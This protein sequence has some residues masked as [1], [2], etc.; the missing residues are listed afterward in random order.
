MAGFLV[1]ARL[2]V[3]S[4]SVT[5]YPVLLFIVR[6]QLFTAVYYKRPYPGPLPV[7][8][9]T[10][11]MVG[12]TTWLTAAGVTISVVLRFVGAAGGLVCVF[13]IPALIHAKVHW[14]RGTLNAWRVLQVS[15]ICAFG[16]YCFAV[17]II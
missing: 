6:S 2:A 17:Q 5:V 1:L 15:S 4:Q 11:V 8:L 7:F 10:M 14:K 12:I 16:I 3:L 13:C 9:I